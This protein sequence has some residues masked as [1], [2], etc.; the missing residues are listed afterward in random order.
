MSQSNVTGLCQVGQ[1][2]KVETRKTQS[3]GGDGPRDEMDQD[4]GETWWCEPGV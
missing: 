2:E 3:R 4:E 1:D